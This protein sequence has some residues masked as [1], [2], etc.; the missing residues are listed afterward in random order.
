[1]ALKFYQQNISQADRRI[2]E[3]EREINRNAIFRLLLI[4]FGGIGIWQLF[5][6]NNI[7]LVLGAI[8]VVILLFAYLVYRQSKIEK[9]LRETGLFFQINENEITVRSSRTN[10]YDQGVGFESS[11]HPYSAD[12]DIF[13]EN[14][15]F[16]YLNRCATS[17]GVDVLSGWLSSPADLQEIVERQAA[18]AELKKDPQHLQAFQ[19]KMFFNRGTS[20][21]LTTIIQH[22]FSDQQPAFDGW[23]YRVYVPLVPWMF[24]A[25]LILILT[26]YPMLP[27]L[28]TLAIT[29]F[30]W[31]LSQAGKVNRVSNRVDKIGTALMA[32][33]EGMKL[34]EDRPY[35]ASLNLDIQARLIMEATDRRLSATIHDLGKLIDKLDVR[36]NMLVGAV[37]NMFLLW[38]FKQVRKINDWTQNY[39]QPIVRGFGAMAQYEALVS[40]ALLSYNHPQWNF[41][42]IEKDK[43]ATIVAE[44]LNHPLIAPQQSVSNN[45]RADDHRIALIT[46]SNMAGKSTFLRTV[47]INAVLAYAGSVV[48]ADYFSLPIFHLVTYMRIKDSLNES[49]ST[50][51]AELNRLKYILDRVGNQPASFFL[52]DE[53]LRGTNSMDKYLGSKAVIE[54]LIQL[55]GRGLLA[56]HDL[57]LSEMTEKHDQILKNFHFDIQVQEGEMLF[58]YK[59]KD[60]ACTVFNASMLLKGIGISIENE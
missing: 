17:E 56:T 59:L 41:P 13:G 14:S 53:M 45:Y 9:D 40:L 22:Y 19:T 24:V 49:T 57:K 27:L 6:F 32:Y 51:K 30:L 16:A 29:H 25:G 44:R 38:D 58:D 18:T 15:L 48:S 3:L 20:V 60:G 10:M 4:I 37:L 52:I 23:I 31:S 28:I 46:G 1:M 11:A 42:K 12:L 8:F 33:A 36:N 55:N 26:G 47:G 39:E 5:G 2:K 34:I 35:N 21:N 50:F 7:S 43:D 54:R